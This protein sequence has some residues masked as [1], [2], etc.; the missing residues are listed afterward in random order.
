M[1][2]QKKLSGK[3]A[4]TNTDYH[5]EELHR[6]A[7]SGDLEAVQRICT[8]NPLV[9][10]SRDKHS[11]TPYPPLFFLTSRLN[12]SP[13]YFSC[14]FVTGI[15]ELLIYTLFITF[16]LLFILANIELGF[17]GQVV[18]GFFF[19][20]VGVVLGMRRKGHWG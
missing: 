19:F 16:F 6:A 4:A 18:L 11:R 13:L 12:F 9:I 15:C 20:L 17:A 8:T 10:N 2:N 7:R 3:P 14:I 1:G 5:D